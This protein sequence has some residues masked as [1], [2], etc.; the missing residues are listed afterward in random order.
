[1]PNIGEAVGGALNALPLDRMFAAP[2]MAMAQSQLALSHQY[3][4][5]IKTV[6]LNADGELVMVKATYE[7]SQTDTQGNV[8]S[9]TKKTVSVPLLSIISHPNVNVQEGSVEFEMTIQ[10]S[11]EETSETQG[12]GGFEATAGWGPF[13]VKIHGSMSHKSA[14]T[15]KTDTR[16]R[17]TVNM[18]IAKD[19]MPEGMHRMLDAVLNASAHPKVEQVA[20][21]T[22]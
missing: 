1:M 22:P 3:L 10:A 16:A 13:K 2:A 18:K 9:T 8:V 12:Q 5:F 6:G 19:D 7:E 21:T 11:E 20:P 17:Y 4:D 14:Q 15:R